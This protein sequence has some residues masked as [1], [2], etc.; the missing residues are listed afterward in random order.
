MT[1]AEYTVSSIVYQIG[2][3][4]RSHV[5]FHRINCYKDFIPHLQRFYSSF[6]IKFKSGAVVKVHLRN[7]NCLD[8][9]ISVPGTFAGYVI[10]TCKARLY[11]G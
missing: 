7:L 11:K 2:N 5:I 3:L 1:E 6:Q 8:V 9:F 4:R 10:Y